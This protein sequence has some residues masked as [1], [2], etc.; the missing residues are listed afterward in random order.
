MKTLFSFLFSLLFI[1]S[2]F[3]QTF[4][5]S[6]EFKRILPN[7][8]S[9]Y[10]YHIKGQKVRIDEMGS[11]GKTVEGSMIVNLTDKKVFALSH[12]RK[13]YMERASKAEDQGKSKMEIE[14]GTNSK[15]I[16]GYKCAQWRV[17]NKEKDSEITY[18]VAEGQFDFFAPLLQVI[19]RKYNFATFYLQVPDTKG[20]FPMLAV[21]RSMLRDEKG[22]LQVTKVTGK[23]IDSSLLEI[24][25]GY[26]K[27][28]K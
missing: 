20:F 14:K 15:F 16:N 13:L 3:A 2:N 21:E 22:R 25:K 27:V 5:G 26:T 18:W 11:D 24:P 7:D 23:T 8:T 17:K 9:V 10:I 6:I 1:T 4:E 19:N 12:D 28:D